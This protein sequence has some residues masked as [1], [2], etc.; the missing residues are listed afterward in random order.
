MPLLHH[1]S[2]PRLKFQ[3]TGT[4]RSDVPSDEDV[5]SQKDTD[6]DS[7]DDD[8]VRSDKDKKT[9]PPKRG[10]AVSSALAASLMKLTS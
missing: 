3:G 5:E 2:W 4:T 8:D 10:N 7:K 9:E 6:Q 1:P